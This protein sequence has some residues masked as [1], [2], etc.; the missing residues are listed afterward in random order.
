MKPDAARADRSAAVR[1]AA[2]SW[3]K[4][5]AINDATLSAIE[6][7][8]PD[9]RVRVGPVF[10]ILLFL[11]TLL[12]VNAGFGLFWLLFLDSASE[13]D[14]ALGWS[15]IL[16]G[17]AL[18]A[19][20]EFQLGS[21]RRSQ[22]GTEA[23]TSLAALGYLI[24]GSGW[25]LFEKFDL[26]E[27]IAFKVLLLV[28]A[29]LLGA[30][31]WRWGYALYA[32]AA[33]AALLACLAALPGGRVLWIAV[34]AVTAPLLVRLSDSA[35]LP[36]AHRGS[37]KAALGVA[38]AGLYVAL[39][40]G[41]FESGLI[42]EIGRFGRN[43]GSASTSSLLWWLSAAATALV[44][45]VYLA[46]GIRTRRYPFLLLGLGTGIA[47]LITLR[48]YVY[49]GPPWAILTVSGAALVAAVFALRRYLDSGP[50]RER[51]GF[52]AEPLFE[53]IGRQRLLEAGA[54]VVSF[55]PEAR[56]VRDEPRFAGGGGE[57]GGGGSTGEF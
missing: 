31:A 52:T 16:F 9:D 56:P 47:S 17:L 15:T 5:D 53:D 7:T 3:K 38:L 6:A 4:A 10:R 23:A 32:G 44:P 24:A 21:L 30:A 57:F 8:Y 14:A 20:T 40:L 39:H 13:K 41:S 29:L 46:V 48:Y 35:R 18:A 12:A 11:F 43:P 50:A 37:C 33:S 54:A 28:A 2:R 42:E 45:V 34:P 1:S 19:F 51:A 25:L 36:P 49:L 26:P 55:S 22:G 27:E